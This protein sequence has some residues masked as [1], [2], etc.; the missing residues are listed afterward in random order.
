MDSNLYARYHVDVYLPDWLRTAAEAFLPHKGTPLPL[1]EHYQKIHVA[2]K[3][4]G[5]LYMPYTFDIIDIT[6][7][8]ITN[9]IFRVLIRA[10]WNSKVDI[11]LALEGDFEVVTAFWANSY[12]L[13]RTLDVNTYEQ[14]PV[15]HSEQALL[16]TLD[17]VLL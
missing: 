3:L 8:R 5:S 6:T 7:V 16:D 13:H 4:P 1:S 12:D 2:R 9:A 11:N 17:D 14:A 15:S 10:P